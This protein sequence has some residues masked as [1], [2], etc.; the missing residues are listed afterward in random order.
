MQRT[1]SN[2]YHNIKEKKHL[3]RWI[4]SPLLSV[5]FPI[6]TQSSYCKWMLLPREHVQICSL[7]S[8]P[9]M[10]VVSLAFKPVTGLKVKAFLLQ[11]VTF[12]KNLVTKWSDHSTN[13]FTI[14]HPNCSNRN[15]LCSSC[16]TIHSEVLPHQGVEEL[17]SPVIVLSSVAPLLCFRISLRPCCILL[18]VVWPLSGLLLWNL[19]Y[20]FT[21]FAKMWNNPCCTW[22]LTVTQRLPS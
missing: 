15:I 21:L 16:L 2:L 7:S 1:S 14:H 6:P 10:A 8:W 20:D 5:Q 3:F 4:I 9:Q 17:L 22:T 11:F 19:D 13:V 18:V 12:G